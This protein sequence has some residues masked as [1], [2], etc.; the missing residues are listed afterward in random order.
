MYKCINVWCIAV[1][2]GGFFEYSSILQLATN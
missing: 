2:V 1:R